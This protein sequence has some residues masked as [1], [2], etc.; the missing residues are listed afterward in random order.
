M[1]M[2]RTRGAVCERRAPAGAGTCATVCF[3]DVPCCVRERA[4][5][6]GAAVQF[7]LVARQ[8]QTTELWE[9]HEHKNS[10]EKLAMEACKYQVGPVKHARGVA[11]ELRAAGGGDVE[12]HAVCRTHFAGTATYW[13]V[14]M[15]TTARVQ[16]LRT[17]RA[18][19]GHSAPT[20]HADT[21]PCCVHWCAV[22]LA[23][24]KLQLDKAGPGEEVQEV[25][26]HHPHRQHLYAPPYTLPEFPFPTFPA[27]PRSCTLLLRSRHWRRRLP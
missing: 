13:G 12:R 10:I 21:D 24:V 7:E 14:L 26:E 16:W 25:L 8:L 4:V 27:S 3:G 2:A 22:L 17:L 23:A 9:H 11:C 1:R 5:T 19:C 6:L 15:A 18:L 20:G